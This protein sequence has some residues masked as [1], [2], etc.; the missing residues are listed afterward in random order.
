MS[1]IC[2]MT[3]WDGIAGVYDLAQWF[4]RRVYREA[5]PRVAQMVPE[6]SSVL[7][8]AAGTG[9]FSLAAAEHAGAVMC[10]DLSRAMLDRAEAKARRRGL[11]NISFL[12]RDLTALPDGDDTYDVVIAANVLHLLPE[13]EEALG[14]LW[15]VTAPGGK[16]ILPTFLLGEARGGGRLMVGLYKKL[17]FS[18][19]RGFTLEGYR[20]FFRH[21]GCPAQVTRIL[22]PIPVGLAVC[23][24]AS[25][26]RGKAARQ[27]RDE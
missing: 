9:E 16:L 4:N 10:T 8:C 5:V 15:R 24:K 22:G 20:N 2:E 19:C 12:V 25:P 6:W 23:E 14:E 26:Y 3:F 21:R 17:G 27:S 7:E 18:P 11:T 1:F 13:P